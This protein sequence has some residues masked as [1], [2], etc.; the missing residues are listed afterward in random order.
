MDS[1]PV[2]WVDAFSPFWDA[3]AFSLAV[4]SEKFCEA[5]IPPKCVVG[6][7]PVPDGVCGGG[8]YGLETEGAVVGLVGGEVFLD[9]EEDEVIYFLGVGDF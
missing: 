8:G 7:I 4:E 3:G 6:D 2:I 9:G 1:W 5:V